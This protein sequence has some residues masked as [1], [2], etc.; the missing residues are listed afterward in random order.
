[1]PPVAGRELHSHMIGES[2]LVYNGDQ[3]RRG[4]GQRRSCVSRPAR[5]SA[6]AVLALT[7]GTS[8]TVHS[9]LKREPWTAHTEA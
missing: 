5:A 6:F 9:A 2:F 1:M 4:G 3:E 7:L 8:Y